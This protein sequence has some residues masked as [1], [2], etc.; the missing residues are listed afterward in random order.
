MFFVIYSP[1]VPVLLTSFAIE[2][3]NNL[4]FAVSSP[5]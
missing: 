5:R 2:T 4:Y 3:E 1:F